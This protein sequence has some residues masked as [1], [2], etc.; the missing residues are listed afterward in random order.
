MIGGRKATGLEQRQPGC[1]EKGDPVS[2]VW[3]E[4]GFGDWS[5]NSVKQL[6][7]TTDRPYFEFAVQTGIRP[8]EQVA[9]GLREAV[10]GGRK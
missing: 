6:E 1:L 9:L 5:E 8:S 10:Y 4:A 3:K 7:R 2:F